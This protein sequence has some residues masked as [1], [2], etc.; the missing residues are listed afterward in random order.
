MIKRA[1]LIEAN[2]IHRGLGMEKNLPSA[3][4]F[5]AAMKPARKTWK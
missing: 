3:G 1:V 5:L 2:V 4:R